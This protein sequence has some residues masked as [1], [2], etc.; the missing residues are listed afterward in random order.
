MERNLIKEK[1]T[2]EVQAYFA[3]TFYHTFFLICVF[4]L[5]FTLFA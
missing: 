1:S 5:F 2:N 4:A 3:D